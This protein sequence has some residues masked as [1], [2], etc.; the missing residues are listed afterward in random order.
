MTSLATDTNTKNT[1]GQ[2]NVDN[3]NN[4]KTIEK[5]LER[6][7]TQE[8]KKELHSPNFAELTPMQKEVLSGV[9]AMCADSLAKLDKNSDMLK[10]SR[11][12]RYIQGQM[13]NMKDAKE[14]LEGAIKWRL[15]NNVE[16]IEQK[17]ANNN[18]K[19]GFMPVEEYP[20]YDLMVKVWPAI[21]FLDGYAK[22]INL[23]VDNEG[24]PIVINQIG[25]SDPTNITEGRVNEEQATLFMIYM[26]AG[27]VLHLTKLSEERKEI[28]R[29]FCVQDLNG[30]GMKHLSSQTRYFIKLFI[31]IMSENFPEVMAKIR[32]INAPWAFT[33][34]WKIIKPLLHP[35]IIKKIKILGKG[36]YQEEILKD[37][38]VHQLPKCYGGTLDI[39]MPA[40]VSEGSDVDEITIS[41]SSIE[42]IHFPISDIT[43]SKLSFQFQC[44]SGD[45]TLI[46]EYFPCILDDS[47]EFEELY[48]EVMDAYEVKRV[49]RKDSGVIDLF[50]SN[51]EEKYGGK[52]ITSGYIIIKFDNSFSWLKSKTVK[53]NINTIDS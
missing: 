11:I 53:Y 19:P 33:V 28:V 34:A 31:R 18:G 15:E 40:L 22:N 41:R 26:A 9:K 30:L 49:E 37:V 3:I 42:K 27:R 48:E 47:K 36:N 14:A 39:L 6:K 43:K 20:Y 23:Q 16:E 1:N 50:I 32:V 5:L 10:D 17:I 38:P 25:M 52:D 46:F 44:N 29:C 4:G 13:F 2:K 21:S 35:R 7:F 12:Y 8:E 24:Q 51:D 45:I